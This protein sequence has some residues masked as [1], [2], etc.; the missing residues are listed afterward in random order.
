MKKTGIYA[1]TAAVLLC[2]AG[3][4]EAQRAPDGRD[5]AA[6]ARPAP[7]VRPNL[8]IPRLDSAP[9]FEN[10]S[11]MKP[12]GI[13]EKMAR[14]DQ[15][16]QRDPRDGEP[17]SQRTEAYLGYDDKNLYAVFL[18]FDS[19][20]DKIR[21]RM[22]RRE[23]AFDDDFVELTVD[24]FHDQRR[25]YV[26]WSNPLGIQ[27][28]ALWTEGNGP[29]FSYDTLWHSR[30]ERTGQGYIVWMAVP[31]RSLRFSSGDVQTW[32]VTLTRVIPRSNEWSYWPY[33]SGKIDGRLNQAASM[34][35]ME[36]ISP[37]RNIQLIPYGVF[38]S[39]RALDQRD[40]AAP[41]YT[42]KTEFD[43]GLDAKFVLKDSLVLD[44]TV[45]PDFAQVESDSPQVTANQRFE[46][47][48]PEKR[49]FFLENSSFFSTPFDLL[50]TRRI[51]DPQFGVRLTG[52]V[53]RYAI[54][55]LF[56]D[57]QSPGRSV[58]AGDPL[59]GQR[60]YFTVVR[61]NRDIF[62]RSTIG[63][64]YTDREFQNESNRVGGIDAR[65]RFSGNWGSTFQSV[66]SATHFSD[67]SQLS[68]PAH[69][70][71]L[72]NFGRK[73]GFETWYVDRGPGFHTDTGFSPRPDIRE[74]GAF[75][76]YNFRPE[77]KRLIFWGPNLSMFKLYDHQ[78]TRL[79]WN[80]R[81]GLVF[82]MQRQTWFEVF[83]LAGRERLRPQD[84]PA[85][86]ANQDY[87]RHRKGFFFE[88]GYWKQVSFGGNYRVGKAVNFV[89]VA[90]QTPVPADETLA[91]AF[92]TVRPVTSLR[93][94]NRYIFSRLT[95]Q[96]T[97]ANIFN[98]HIFRQNWNWQFTRE[99]SARVILQ[100]NTLIT[101]PG[102]S[103][104]EK[105]RNFNADFL[106]TYLLNP[107][108]AL[109]VGY[110]SN[111]QNVALVP[112]APGAGCSTQITRTNQFA[113]D[114]KGLF[115]KFSYLFRF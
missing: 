7:P 106:I 3:L 83:Y 88:T 6:A 99:L 82:E 68:G 114:A 91:N 38:R 35:G 43:G 47:F 9:T 18:A 19:E 80:T 17:C 45:N 66:Y 32:G 28:E 46:L 11:G 50:F 113:N 53:G 102:L 96:P 15:F 30:G 44:V 25:G 98:N 48:F 110:N 2:L 103:E 95:D 5:T 51:A 36:R 71:N 85:L 20:P 12:A 73:F 4:V 92:F 115:V 52:K 70:A 49:P 67:G 90:G 93:V 60:A 24:T 1:V 58:P 40:P 108:T 23:D 72:Y 27:A 56:A 64:L 74:F 21:A 10:F 97:G 33:V 104:L 22:T 26:F 89:P 111:L 105:R 39:F 16:T 79:E 107:G 41:A 94:E 101:N 65:L 13:A 109:Y 37:G 55:A 59:E 75:T 78:G 63:V 77:G 69:F 57:D 42:S 87:S 100:Y 34:N 62:K 54:G 61:V 8:V 76:R 112:C 14:V 29:D 86:P 84:F 81:G 31:F